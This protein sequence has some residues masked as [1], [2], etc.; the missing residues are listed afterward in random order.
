MRSNHPLEFPASDAGQAHQKANGHI[1][2]FTFRFRLREHIF[3]ITTIIPFLA[4]LWP[5]YLN[6]K[7][8]TITM[9]LLLSISSTTITTIIIITITIIISVLGKSG[10]GELGPG[11]LGPGQ[12]G[13]TVRGPIV[14]L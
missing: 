13:P 6:A 4:L 11:Q 9:S 1:E 12:S 14:H 7:H 8:M 3:K 5:W 2:V 10:P